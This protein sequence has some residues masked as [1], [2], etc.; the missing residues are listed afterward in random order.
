M[1]KADRTISYAQYKED[2]ILEALLYDIKEGFYIDVGANYPVVD[3]VTKRFYDKGWR[4]INIEPVKQLYEQLV[5]ARPRDINLQCGAGSK[6]GT[7]I[8]R[9]YIDASGHSTFDAKQKKAHDASDSYKDYEVDIRPLTDILAEHKLPQIDFMKID[10][11][12]FEH[13]VIAGN[14]WA[15]NRP[16]IICIEDNHT[17]ENWAKI[18]TDAG[19]KRYIADGLNSYYV[20]I[21]E[22]GRTADF[23]E[24]VI[25]L[26]Y[27]TLRQHQA[28]SWQIDIEALRAQDA[29]IKNQ[30]I[31]L[32]GLHKRVK[33][34]ESAG[35]L[36]LKD[37]PYRQRITAAIYGLTID[38]LR[39]KGWFK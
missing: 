36:S 17:T 39:F 37:K 38:W 18:L 5:A 30:A 6:A 8:L 4:G 1:V 23:P 14:D 33:K 2:V 31:Q 12:G 19:Y 26:D 9:E 20:A 27:Y 10:V 21:E 11:E 25:K 24:R 28:E 29:H 35:T 3:S 32:E 16:K 13:E 22:W 34:L 7:A 15:K